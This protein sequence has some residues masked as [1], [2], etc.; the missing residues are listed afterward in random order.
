MNH[1]LMAANT[2]LFICACSLEAATLTWNGGGSDGNWSTA[3]N[4]NSGLAPVSGDSLVFGGTTNLSAN[5]GSGSWNWYPNSLS[6]A[7]GAGAFTLYGGGIH[8][9]SGGITNN[10]TNTQTISSQLYLDANQTWNASSGALVISGG[11]YINGGDNALTVTGSS[12]VTIE[13]QLGNVSTLT[14]SGSGNRAFTSTSTLSAT[15]L[16][17]SGTGTT[18]FAAQVNTTTINLTSGTT[19]F[20]NTGTSAQAGNGGINISGTAAATFSGNVAGGRGGINI[21][22]SGNVNFN[23]HIT[24][25]SLTLNGTGTT[26]L[27]GDGSNN[28]SSTTV[29]SGTLILAETGGGDAINGPLVV[30]SGGT[31]IFAGDDQIPSWQTVTLNTGSTLLLGDTSQTFTNLIINGNSVIDFGS[32]GSQINVSGNLTIAEGITITIL[33]WNASVGDV[34]AGTNPGTPVVNVQYADSTGTVYATGTWGG[35]YVTPG[36]PVPEPATYGLLMIG[37][38]IAFF[39]WRRREAS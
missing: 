7:S 18:T 31:V 35:G 4:W 36:A 25:G 26:T 24:G 10:S 2:L 8:I 32:G 9:G 6:F 27:A 11:S 37:T 39:L 16:T 15:T 28:I 30:N 3:A 5:A 12:S 21:T 20:T 14:L 1:R 13:H 34:F 17:S 23:G 22:S 29:N 38:G 33:N 19:N